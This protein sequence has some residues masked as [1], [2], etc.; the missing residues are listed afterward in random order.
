MRPGGAG[1]GHDAEMA[2]VTM[3]RGLR[4]YHDLLA[5]P[6]A[7][8]LVG[9]GLVARMPIGMIGLAQV[10]LMRGSGESYADAGLVA[11]GGSLAY[12]VGAPV[13][14][15]LVD[16][17]RPFSVLIGYGVIFPAALA[18]L[19]VLVAADAPLW[20]LVVA[21]MLSGASQPP[22]APTVR[23]LWSS[24]VSP[25]HHSAAFAFEATAQE[26]L[27]ITGPLV[28]GVL[29]AAF[30]PSAGVIAAGVVSAVGV[31]GFVMTGP[32]RDRL[33]APHEH[34][35]HGHPLSTLAPPMVRRIVAFS[36]GYGLAFGA[37]EVAMPAFAEAH[38]GRALGSVCL[39]AWSA[40][41]LIGGVLAAGHRPADPLRS[42][43]MIS[44]LF[45]V[46]LL[47]P[48]LA[49]SVWAMAMIM[50]IAGLPIA[51]SFAL[52]YGMVQHTARPGTQAEVFGWLS[53]AIGV[54]FAGGAALGGSLITRSGTSASILLGV[55]GALVAVAVVM[56]PRP[57]M[58]GPAG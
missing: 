17:R 34:G 47:L 42:L 53:T 38:G 19:V 49:G 12:A 36:I 20:L 37:V 31:A 29:T 8:G 18:L 44:M 58:A 54:G 41:S 2:G 27:F 6:G 26:L 52:T 56:L 32:V 25:R 30:S 11:A 40:G 14:G 13:A 43:R 39:A 10:L 1:H 57:A 22:V 16:R 28:V 35:R 3:T 23:M 45:A 9:W 4:S 15:R 51:P 33:P 24:L 50:L 5:Q 48:L 55:A 7:A 46:L 21:S